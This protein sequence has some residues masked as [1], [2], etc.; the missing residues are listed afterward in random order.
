MK[1]KSMICLVSIVLAVALLFGCAGLQITDVQQVGVEIISDELGCYLQKEA[2]NET[3]EILPLMKV[4]ADGGGSQE[5][6]NSIA[7]KLGEIAGTAISPRMG[8]HISRLSKLFT[9]NAELPE[10]PPI[11]QSAA[12]AFVEGAEFCA[13]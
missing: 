8:R 7:M 11:I 13:E 5:I 2:P 12:S 10:I 1:E 3:G 6:I 9:I 4:V